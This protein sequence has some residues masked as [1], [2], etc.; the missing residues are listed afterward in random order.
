QAN[1]LGGSDLQV[2]VTHV[3]AGVL[4]V[5]PEGGLHAHP[6]V[7]VADVA[8]AAVLFG[9]RRSTALVVHGLSFGGSVFFGHFNLE[10]V[11]VVELEGGWP[12]DLVGASG[13]GFFDH[14]V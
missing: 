5:G 3:G 2:G 12:V 6:V 7:H 11:G 9:H 8:G 10:D 4:K 13:L 1:Y 14:F